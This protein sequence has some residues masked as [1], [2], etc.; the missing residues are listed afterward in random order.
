MEFN[1][2]QY[3]MAG[4]VLL[5]LGVQLRLVEAFVLN[6]RA[7]QFMAQRIQQIK[8]QPSPGDA[9]TLVAAQ[10]PAGKHRL[11]RPKW[12]GYSVMSIGGVLVLYSLALKKPG[13]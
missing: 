12:L 7:T 13:G 10:A 8:A 11:Q 5:L 3:F 9:T 4:L 1:R 2:N 6:E